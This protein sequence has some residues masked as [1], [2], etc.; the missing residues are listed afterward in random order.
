MSVNKVAYRK[1]CAVDIEQFRYDISV[2][3][4]GNC[5]LSHGTSDYLDCL[6][7]SYDI[8]LRDILDHH[9]PVK[10]NTI[11]ERPHVLWF[12]VEIRKAKK[13]RRKSERKWRRI[14]LQHDYDWF[15]LKKNNFTFLLNNARR[16]YYTNC[17]NE[18]S[19]DQRTF[20]KASRSLLN[21][22]NTSMFPPHTDDFKLANEMGTIFVKK[23]KNIR[24]RLSDENCS[25][26][27]SAPVSSAPVALVT[28]V[29]EVL[30]K[31]NQLSEI[32]VRKLILNSSKKCCTLDPIP[33]KLLIDSLDVLL[34]VIT[35]LVHFSLSSIGNGGSGA[36]G[37]FFG[38]FWRNRG[39]LWLGSL[40]TLLGLPAPLL[41]PI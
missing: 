17:I 7:D 27:P 34:P 31:F 30:T 18:N 32:S 22:N 21:L 19:V 40:F 15:K 37:P 11:T 38:P 35:Q 4:L 9:A 33:P 25:P 12:N 24:L 6:A 5:D 10:T 8:I 36:L 2:S 20:F 13:E 3:D 26:P 16:E 1:I 39:S 29:G 23:I 28:K 14:E 41:Q